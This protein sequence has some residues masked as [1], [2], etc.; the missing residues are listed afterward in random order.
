MKTEQDREKL[1]EAINVLLNQS[2]DDTLDEIY[3]LLQKIEYEEDE[4][5]LRAY[6]HA[7]KNYDIN[8][9]I[10]WDDAKKELQTEVD[11]EVA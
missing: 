7:M 2:Y 10:S 4:S 9:T 1:I 11:K 8:D 3:A 5:D 6:E